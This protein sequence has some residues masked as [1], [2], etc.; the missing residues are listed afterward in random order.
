MTTNTGQG[1]QSCLE[2]ATG[3][4][5]AYPAWETGGLP[6]TYAGVVP[7]SPGCH[8]AASAFALRPMTSGCPASVFPSG[9]AVSQGLAPC[10]PTSGHGCAPCGR[11]IYMAKC[12]LAPLIS[13]RSKRR[14]R[15]RKERPLGSGIPPASAP[16]FRGVDKKE[17]LH[18]VSRIEPSGQGISPEPCTTHGFGVGGT[19]RNRTG[20]FQFIRHMLA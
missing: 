9:F 7:V 1:Y 2:P 13:L 3:V 17:K 18:E 4:G 20:I 8:A 5:P 19:G 6:L 16:S 15:I 12:R 10:G 14:N 11:C